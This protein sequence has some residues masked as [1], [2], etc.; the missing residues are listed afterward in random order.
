MRSVVIVLY[1]LVL[2]SFCARA[3]EHSD[4]ASLFSSEA[5]ARSLAMG[6]AS[7]GLVGGESLVFSNAAGLAWSN[8]VV[9]GSSVEMRS[10]TGMYGA[11]CGSI[12]HFGA[13][14]RYFDFGAVP[15]TDDFGNV[16]GTFPYR[17]YA[18]VAGVGVKATDLPFVPR[19]AFAEQV[20]TGLSVKL[21]KVSTLE[22]G[23]GGGLA[24]DLP[25]LFRGDSAGLVTGYGMGLV[26]ENLIGIPI[27]YGSGHE[28][29]WPRN[30]TLGASLEFLS[31]AI[32]AVD[33]TTENSLRFGVEW[34]PVPALSVRS[35]L[36]REGI[37][38]WSLGIGARFG[39]FALDCAVVTH[40]YLS[41]QLCS[42][43]AA[44]W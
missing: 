14:V 19:S 30:L 9:F 3:A 40:P 11:I 33:L 8:G 6:G 10:G 36:R 32:L 1:L 38:I 5:S 43:L 24:L 22:P 20:A 16:V 31:Q 35:G 13:G 34:T 41:S 4:V 15:E 23:S 26:F 12:A 39:N 7:I 21:F 44:S 25:L 18:V 27:R 2:A 28:E 17:N 42:S 37:W 29:S